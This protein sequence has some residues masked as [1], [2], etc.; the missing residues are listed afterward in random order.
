MKKL[1][2]PRV[3]RNLIHSGNSFSYGNHLYTF[4]IS[5]ID[6]ITKSCRI[7]RIIKSR[8]IYLVEH[9]DKPKIVIVCAINPALYLCKCSSGSDILHIETKFCSILRI[10]SVCIISPCCISCIMRDLINL[11]TMFTIRK[12]DSTNRCKSRTKKNI[13]RIHYFIGHP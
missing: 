8:I 9:K 10:I 2:F 6:N 7:Y 5:I 4:C 1:S 12:Y 11:R 3:F 13:S